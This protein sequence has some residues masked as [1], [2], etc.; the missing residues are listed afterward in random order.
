MYILAFMLS[1]PSLYAGLVCRTFLGHENLLFRMNS[2]TQFEYPLLIGVGSETSNVFAYPKS[3]QKWEPAVPGN[4]SCS[5]PRCFVELLLLQSYLCTILSNLVSSDIRCRISFCR[6]PFV[7]TS[8]L[9]KI[10]LRHPVSFRSS[11][12]SVARHTHTF[13]TVLGVP[14]PTERDPDYSSIS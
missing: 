12:P 10:I 3:I 7:C 14:S 13:I 8:G 4:I 1:W 11:R 9:S 6:P 2:M 5:R